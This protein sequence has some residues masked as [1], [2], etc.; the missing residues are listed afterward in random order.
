MLGFRW[1]EPGSE[2]EVGGEELGGLG[3]FFDGVQDEGGE[4]WVAGG[5]AF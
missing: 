5:A 4:G 2:G 3:G 1:L